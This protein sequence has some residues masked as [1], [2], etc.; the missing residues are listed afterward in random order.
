MLPNGLF[1][2]FF[3]PHEGQRND[4]FML[5]ESMI[6]EPCAEHAVR[7]GTDE[8][9]MDED[10]YFQL[11]GDPAYGV[12]AHIQSPFSGVGNRT[13]LQKEWNEL[14]SGVRIEV[15]HGFGIVSNT[16][17]FLN[18]G[19]K[20]HLAASPVGHYYWVGVLLTNGID[21]LHLNQVAQAFDCQPPELKNYFHH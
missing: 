8:N 4:S 14:M 10:R 12:S 7:E 18:A 21:C 20:M 2:H 1:G 11:F 17:P 13:A 6:L 15:E 16:W 19:W 3:G 9:S 5:N